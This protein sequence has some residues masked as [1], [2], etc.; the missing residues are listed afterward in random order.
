MTPAKWSTPQFV[1]ACPPSLPGGGVATFCVVMFWVPTCWVI[2]VKEQRLFGH[3]DFIKGC[4][5]SFT[6]SA[7]AR[8]KI[9]HPTRTTGKFDNLGIAGEESEIMGSGGRDGEAVAKGNGGARL[10][11]RHLDHPRCTG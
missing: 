9:L 10:Q 1:F 3:S 6:P 2:S 4:S 8:A 11:A 7:S 5:A